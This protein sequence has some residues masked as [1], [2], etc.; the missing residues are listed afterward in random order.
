MGSDSIRSPVDARGVPQY[1]KAMVAL[2]VTID[3]SSSTLVVP[4]D[5]YWA[6]R[7]PALLPGSPVI[8]ATTPGGT[9]PRTVA[10]FPANKVVAVSPFHLPSLS[11]FDDALYRLAVHQVMLARFMDSAPRPFVRLHGRHFSDCCLLG[12]YRASRISS[13]RLFLSPLPL[14]AA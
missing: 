11:R 14:L 5:R 6:H 13:K 12:L 1:L 7:V 9:S 10:G 8:L 3:V 2:Q 4:G